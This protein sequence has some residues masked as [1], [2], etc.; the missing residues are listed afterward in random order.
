M[1]EEKHVLDRDAVRLA[2]VAKFG[3][4]AYIA[5]QVFAEGRFL[6]AIAGQ[7]QPCRDGHAALTGRAAGLQFLRDCSQ[8]QQ[9]VVV[10]GGF[11]PLDR[12]PPTATNK[13]TPA[14]R[15]HVLAGVRLMAAAGCNASREGTVS[16]FDGVIAVVDTDDHGMPRFLY[17]YN[18]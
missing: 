7:G 5:Q 10:V 6:A 16:G 9:V 11:V 4:L 14:E 15:K 13:K 12:L 17:N 1:G 8:R 18:I 2:F 3:R